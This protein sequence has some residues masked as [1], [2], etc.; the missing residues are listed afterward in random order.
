MRS[1]VVQVVATSLQRPGDGRDGGN[2]LAVVVAREA[3]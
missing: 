3:R 1:K 2:H